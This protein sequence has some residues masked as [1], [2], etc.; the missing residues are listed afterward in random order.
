MKASDPPQSFGAVIAKALRPL[1][2]GTGLIPVLIA[3]H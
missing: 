1:Y 2:G 3:L